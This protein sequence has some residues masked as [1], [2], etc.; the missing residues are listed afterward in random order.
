MIAGEI[1]I[2]TGQECEAVYDL[3]GQL[4]GDNPEN[5][6]SPY[7]DDDPNN[8]TTRAL[9]KI[10]RAAGARVPEYLLEKEQT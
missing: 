8:P 9:V 6:W 5:I 1:V 10:Y 7:N 2:L 4:S 3:F